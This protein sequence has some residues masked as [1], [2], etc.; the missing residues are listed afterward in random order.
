MDQVLHD[1]LYLKPWI[2]GSLV[3]QESCRAFPCLGGLYAGPQKHIRLAVLYSG[4]RCPVGKK[5]SMKLYLDN[6]GA[7]TGGEFHFFP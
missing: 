5:T 1:P 3:F 6:P 4:H 2:Y 7:P